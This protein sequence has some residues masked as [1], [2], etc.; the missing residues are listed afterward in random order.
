MTAKEK[1]AAFAWGGFGGVLP[2]L[3]KLASTY[4]VAPASPLP[5]LGL[6]IGL[7]LWAVVGGGVALTSTSYETRQAIFAGIAA[8]AMITSLV[9]GT[10]QHQTAYSM[11]SLLSSALAQESDNFPSR[12]DD[13]AIIVSPKIQGGKPSSV[14]IPVTAEVKSESGSVQR[15]QIGEIKDL[16][17]PSAFAVPPGA[18]QVFIMDKSVDTGDAL[19]SVDLSVRTSPSNAGDFL[20]ALGGRRKFQIEELEVSGAASDQHR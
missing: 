9:S 19:T 11:P 16:S 3:A 10:T 14:S 2:T 18:T 5:E 7:L 8:P 4:V 13:R 12:L 1:I 20:W 6:M 17:A 15:V